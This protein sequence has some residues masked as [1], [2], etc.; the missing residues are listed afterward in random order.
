LLESAIFTS[1]TEYDK[2][3]AS[4]VD[5]MRQLPYYTVVGLRVNLK[6]EVGQARATNTPCPGSNL[7]TRFDSG[8]FYH[9]PPRHATPRKNVRSIF[10]MGLQPGLARGKRKA[11]W[12]HAQGKRSWAI[13]HVAQRHHVAAANVVVLAVRVSRSLLRRNRRGLW[14]CP[15]LISPRD[16]LAVNGLK[17]F[18]A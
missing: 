4:A 6:N 15:F 14:Y 13:K 8:Q 18:V 2:N 7:L 1:Q 17:L 5:K 11:V 10:S 16:I 3:T 12:L 9:P